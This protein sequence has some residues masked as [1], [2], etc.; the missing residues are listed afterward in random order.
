MGSKVDGG[1][2]VSSSRLK[3]GYEFIVTLVVDR[4]EAE[5]DWDSS[6]ADPDAGGIAEIH[7][8]RVL[9]EAHKP[10]CVDFHYKYGQLTRWRKKVL[11]HLKKYEGKIPAAHR[12]K[13]VE[14]VKSDFNFLEEALELSPDQ[15]KRKA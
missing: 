6:F 4:I 15:K 8:L 12:E 3:D 10:R 7:A 13:F 2:P 1:T 14:A 11:D 5:L 9:V